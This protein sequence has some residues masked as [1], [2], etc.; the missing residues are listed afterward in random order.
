VHSHFLIDERKAVMHFCIVG[1]DESFNDPSP[2]LVLHA[3]SIRMA[4]A[5]GI[6]T[7]DFMRGNE[8]YKYSFGACDRQVRP[9]VV[10]HHSRI[11]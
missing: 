8:P 2:G 7:Y 5:R 1:R 3:H 10:T 6:R 4:I 9:I 11:M